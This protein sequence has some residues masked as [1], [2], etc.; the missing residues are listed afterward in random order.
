LSVKLDAETANSTLQKLNAAML[1]VQ[2]DK[3]RY[4]KLADAFAAYWTPLVVSCCLICTAIMILNVHRLVAV[5]K[6][7]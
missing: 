7:W 3:G 5:F 6:S 4:A 1:D 2:A